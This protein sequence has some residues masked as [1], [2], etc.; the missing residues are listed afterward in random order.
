M[1]A[2]RIPT[3]MV[4]ALV[5][6]N[7]N[8]AY[9]KLVDI[10]EQQSS[11]KRLRRASDGPAD[12]NLAMVHRQ[13]LRREDQFARNLQ[14]AQAMLNVTDSAL[15]LS[16]DYITQ[17]RS[18]TIQAGGGAINQTARVAIADQIDSLRGSLI[19]LANTT[20]GTR[21]VFAGISDLGA[22]VQP[23]GTYTD[24][25]V[26]PAYGG[27]A[28]HDVPVMRPVA[29]GE[30]IQV[31]VA[32]TAAFGPPV[33]GP[34]APYN[35]NLFQILTQL[36]TDIRSGVPAQLT[37]AT[38]TGLD[39]I[40][41]ARN[42]MGVAQGQLGAHQARVDDLTSRNLATSLALQ[43]QL[44][45]LENIDLAKVTIDLQTQTLAYQ[46]ALSATSRLI[47]TSLVDFLR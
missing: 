16:Q 3:A 13:D 23:N 44:S 27:I 22:P 42:Q 37:Q 26:S 8:T 41:A 6:R 47:G 28:K 9:S 32:L 19:S 17:I 18:L 35:G 2:S 40:D 43:T 11:G 1:N 21:P 20:Y 15:Q 45:D 24:V 7:V 38:T 46:A 12:T 33:I 29:N 4:S 39:A 36:S 10:G 30:Q 34:P 14:D 25:S 31:N 5:Q